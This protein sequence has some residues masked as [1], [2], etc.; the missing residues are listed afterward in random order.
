MPRCSTF[1]LADFSQLWSIS[2][3]PTRHAIAFVCT[4]DDGRSNFPLSW[5]IDYTIAGGAAQDDME[6]NA[7]NVSPE[8]HSN[9]AIQ[10]KTISST[11][12]GPTERQSVIVVVSLLLLLLLMLMML[13]RIEMVKWLIQAHTRTR[14]PLVATSRLNR[15]FSIMC[16]TDW[17]TDWLE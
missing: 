13:R 5:A 6:W 10:K 1:S 14:S 7:R 17:L 16:H 3:P 4:L 15:G 2:S 9:R 11:W 8:C 12:L